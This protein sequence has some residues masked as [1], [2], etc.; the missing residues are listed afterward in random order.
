MIH[1]NYSKED[2]V[3]VVLHRSHPRRL[4]NSWVAERDFGHRYR[5]RLMQLS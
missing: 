3:V 4:L 2:L 5:H 1:L